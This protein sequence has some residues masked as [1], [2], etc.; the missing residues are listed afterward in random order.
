[1][2]STAQTFEKVLTK[3][4]ELKLILFRWKISHAVPLLKQHINKINWDM[5]CTNIA[6]EAVELLEKYPEKINWFYL[7]TNHNAS[8]LL[9]KNIDKIVWSQLSF[10][11]SHFAIELLKKK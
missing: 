10:N 5:L 9:Q 1:M 2:C 4:Y 3:Y 8:H 7:S 11:S 6:F